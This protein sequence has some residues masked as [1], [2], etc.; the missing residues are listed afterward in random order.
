MDD[1]GVTFL[2]MRMMMIINAVN[3]SIGHPAPGY[4]TFDRQYTRWEARS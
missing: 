3:S 1:K 2:A 4:L